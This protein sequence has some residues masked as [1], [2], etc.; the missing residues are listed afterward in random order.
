[1]HTC[2]LTRRVRPLAI[3]AAYELLEEKVPAVLNRMDAT[4]KAP[5]PT[6][7]EYLKK[8][9]LLIM[10]EGYGKK[11]QSFIEVVEEAYECVCF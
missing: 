6:T 1:M 10:K 9:R 8:I 3:Q 2:E 5:T 7:P 11:E 4:D